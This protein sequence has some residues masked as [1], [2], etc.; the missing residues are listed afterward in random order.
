MKIMSSTTFYSHQRNYICPAVEINTTTRNR[1]IFI[2]YMDLFIVVT[3][4]GNVIEQ[5]QGSWII[6]CRWWEVWL[7]RF[8]HQV[9]YLFTESQNILH[10]EIIDKREVQLKSPNMEREALKRSLDYLCTCVNV[11]ELVTDASTSVIKLLSKHGVRHLHKYTFINAATRYP[12]VIHSLDIWH[13]AKKLKKAL[14]E[15]Q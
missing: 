9:L 11:K 12:E 15:V 8:K 13:K 6:T 1:Y 14:L 7:T 5:L 10:M 3:I 4:T 2:V